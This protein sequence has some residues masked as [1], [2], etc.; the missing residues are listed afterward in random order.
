MQ[1][2]LDPI[3]HQSTAGK[4]AKPLASNIAARTV[5]VS[6]NQAEQYAKVSTEE[7]S[8]SKDVSTFLLP[9]L[10]EIVRRT[11]TCERNGLT[12]T[13]YLDI[14]RAEIADHYV[15]SIYEG[16]D[17]KLV[18]RSS[19]AIL[20]KVLEMLL[21]TEFLPSDASPPFIK[22]ATNLPEN[23]A[24]AKS[25][26]VKFL[27]ISS[28]FPSIKPDIHQEI[29]GRVPEI[30]TALGI[31]PAALRKHIHCPFK[32]HED[33]HPSFRIDAS[34]ARFYCSCTHGSGSMIDLVMR[35]HGHS[36]ARQ[37][38]CCTKGAGALTER[39]SNRSRGSTI[40]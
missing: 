28:I 3:N 1:P 35:L 9:A 12:V 23:A 29:Q 30:L 31:D 18:G 20:P 4:S 19:Y 5:C 27:Q 34:K 37:Q 32:A 22:K 24:T 36:T 40:A 2:S 6:F 16:D 25:E 10:D 39:K 13:R 14:K 15:Y 11:W 38:G 26:P 17:A 21:Q 8:V 7:K 33:R